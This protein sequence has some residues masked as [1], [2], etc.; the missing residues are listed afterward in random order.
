MKGLLYKEYLHLRNFHFFLAIV[1]LVVYF[2]IGEWYIPEQSENSRILNGSFVWCIMDWATLIAAYFSFQVDEKEKWNLCALSLPVSKKLLVKSRYLSLCSILLAG[3]F[4]GVLLTV[5][6][7]GFQPDVLVKYYCWDLGFMLVLLSAFLPSAYRMGA[8]GSLWVVILVYILV[9][10][11]MVAAERHGFLSWADSLLFG[12]TPVFFLAFA[13]TL[14][15][16][17]YFL[18]CKA[19]NTSDLH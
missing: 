14:F 2:M 5:L 17:S 12:A 13:L 16:G 8:Q 9:S 19:L 10:I 1:F 3:N 7:P 6:S 11:V 18:S 15:L 4:L